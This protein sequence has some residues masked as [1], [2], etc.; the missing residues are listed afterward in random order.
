M[1]TKEFFVTCIEAI[2]KEEEYLH[3]FSKAIAELLE[4]GEGWPKIYA[5]KNKLV[6]WLQNELNDGGPHSVIE[7]YLWELDFGRKADQLH[8]Y[9][10][11]EERI[12]DT[13][14]KLYDL[15]IEL[16]SPTK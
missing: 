6:E 13:P 5:C 16:K 9:I 15:L 4:D 1:I 14:E 7:W 2:A 3:K 8:F 10:N 11:Q 12:V